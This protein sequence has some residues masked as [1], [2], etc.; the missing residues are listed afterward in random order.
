MVLLWSPT[1]AACP[2]ETLR[3]L[4]MATIGRDT[5]LIHFRGASSMS[6]PSPAW[7]RFGYAADD[8]HIR[9][10]VLKCRGRLLTRPLI[11]LDRA[12]VQA[13]LYGH[14]H[15]L[16]ALSVAVEDGFKVGF[17]AVVGAPLGAKGDGLY[18]GRI[19]PRGAPTES[20]PSPSSEY[21]ELITSLTAH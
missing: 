6:Q 10:Q 9:L 4:H 18:D 2:T 1:H 16:G 14:L 20:S 3:R 12:A 17:D 5:M 8:S 7:L 13:R 15:A 19:A 11:T 21:A